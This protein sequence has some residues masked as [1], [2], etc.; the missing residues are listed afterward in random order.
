VF[1]EPAELIVLE[2]G[3]I[4]G[5]YLDRSDILWDNTTVTGVQLS[6]Q[7]LD[8]NLVSGALQSG[9]Y[10]GSFT[11][12]KNLNMQTPSR[13]A[14]TLYYYSI[15]DQPPPSLPT[16]AGVYTGMAF[17]DK[18]LQQMM[19][20]VRISS[21]GAITADTTQGCKATG[22]ITPRPSGKNILNITMRFQGGNCALGDGTAVRGVAMYETA[23]GVGAL[24]IIS[25][26]D[27]KSAGLIFVV[28][29]PRNG[30]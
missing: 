21:S 12:K 13:V 10:F 3:E 9:S 2:N 29:K 18:L 30:S 26:N 22:T 28:S 24:T 8:L 19:W 11:A 25:L 15:Y 14:L 1:A 7:G 16:V 17:P 5:S 27:A 4:W 6:G 23:G 20:T